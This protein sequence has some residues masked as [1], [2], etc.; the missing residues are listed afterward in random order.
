MFIAE[1]V[2]YGLDRVERDEGDFHKNG[3]PVG[4]GPV[5]EP[6]KLKGLEFTA[7]FR[8]PGNQDC[9]GIDILLEVKWIAPVVSDA[10]DDI[11]GVEVGR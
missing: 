4:H 10:G 3:I 7:V 9:T 8:F 1:Q 11:H 6:G 2:I 5:P